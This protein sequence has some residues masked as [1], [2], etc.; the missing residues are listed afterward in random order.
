[1]AEM[2]ATTSFDYLWEAKDTL[3]TRV[4]KP[5]LDVTLALAGLIVLSPVL[6]AASIAVASTSSG[7]ILFRQTRVGKLGKTFSIYKFR[8]MYT[9]D[10]P[11]A[12]LLTASGDPRITPVGKWLRSSK[13][14]EL[15]QLFNVLKG[16]M[17]IVGPRPE[18][19]AYVSLLNEV[20]RRVLSLR[21]G[22][23]GPS[24]NMLEEELLAT[25]ADTENFYVSTVL[26]AKLSI[27]CKYCDQVSLRTDLT[28]IF[29]TAFKVLR[30][31]AEL[32][33]PSSSVSHRQ[34]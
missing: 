2:N 4:G 28:L 15:P 25:H 12:A 32:C 24:A 30:R 17:S 33:V 10:R 6:V 13:I 27:D 11:A 19:P 29:R 22:I 34:Q 8:S 18:V 31:V 16:E 1:M 20:Q 14:D 21:P 23:T 3:Y 5:C 26:P 7:P 9:S